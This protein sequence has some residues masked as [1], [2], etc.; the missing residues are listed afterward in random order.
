MYNVYFYFLV[1]LVSMICAS[2]GVFERLKL[3]LVASND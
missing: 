2:T 3:G 1:D